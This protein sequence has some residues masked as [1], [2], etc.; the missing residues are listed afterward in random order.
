MAIGQDPLMIVRFFDIL[1]HGMYITIQFMFMLVD[2]IL[3]ALNDSQ[4]ITIVALPSFE[5]SML[6]YLTLLFG[7]DGS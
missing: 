4:V 6:L 3:M 7:Y 5:K 1:H 2:Q